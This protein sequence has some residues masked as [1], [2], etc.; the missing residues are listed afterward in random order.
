MKWDRRGA[1]VC[2]NGYNA[3]VSG[4]SRRASGGNRVTGWRYTF[5]GANTECSSA[6]HTLRRHPVPRE[7]GFHQATAL[8]PGR[9]I[10]EVGQG[11]FFL[12]TGVGIVVSVHFSDPCNLAVDGRRLAPFHSARCRLERLSCSASSRRTAPSAFQRVASL[13]AR[14]GRVRA[15]PTSQPRLI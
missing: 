2:S 5:R 1:M 14:A 13:F 12:L 6:R 11:T 15:G 3:G 4:P 8:T 9:E 7:N 10:T